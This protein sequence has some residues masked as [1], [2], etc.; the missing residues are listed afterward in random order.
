MLQGPPPCCLHTADPDHSSAVCIFS[1]LW[2]LLR[3]TTQKDPTFFYG[4]IVLPCIDN[5]VSYHFSMGEH[6]H[7]LHSVQFFSPYKECHSMNEL[8]QSTISH[9]CVDSFKIYWQKQSDCVNGTHTWSSERQA[10]LPRG[11]TYHTARVSEKQTLAKSLPTNN[12]SSTSF[13]LSANLIGKKLISKSGFN[14]HF[15]Q[16]SEAGNIFIYLALLSMPL[17]IFFPIDYWSFSY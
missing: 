2:I 11:S 5:G 17:P 15:S 9:D 10:A 14:F 12:I 3:N 4:C 7:Y 8:V 1:T 13:A 16:M 6:W